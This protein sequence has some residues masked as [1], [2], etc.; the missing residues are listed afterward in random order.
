MKRICKLLCLVLAFAMLMSLGCIAFASGEPSGTPMGGGGNSNTAL[1]AD[2]ADLETIEAEFWVTTTEDRVGMEGPVFDNEGNLYVCSVGMTYP[3]NYILKIDEE[4]NITTVWEG[5]LSPLGLAFHENGKLFAVCREGEILVMDKDGSNVTSLTPVYGEWSFSLN[6]LC[7]T[8][9][10]DLIFTDWQGT[11]ADPI[12]GIY[13]LT[14][15]SDYQ[16]VTVLADKL[17]GPNGV[18]LSP[19]GNTLWVGMTNQDAIYRI[20]LAYADGNVTAAKIELVYQN[21]GAGNPDSNEV[22][23]AGNLYQAMIQGG[24]V[25][26]LN[27]EGTPVANVIIPE[28]EQGKRMMSSNLAIKPGT[29]EAY[30]LTAGFGEGSHIYTF[31]VLAEPVQV[32]ASGEASGEASAE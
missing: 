18:S 4:K 13:V 29:N 15:E 28:R 9:D 30:L 11:E 16:E 5:E 22:D 6:D 1:P 23:S 3:I 17:P 26:V 14:A 7:F 21:S 27:S 20:E 8:A 2:V 12:G 24:R 31:E 25:L 10:G 19:D 32:N